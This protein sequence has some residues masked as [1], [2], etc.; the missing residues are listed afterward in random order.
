MVMALNLIPVKAQNK[1]VNAYVLEADLSIKEIPFIWRY[2]FYWVSTRTPLA[3]MMLRMATMWERPDA[4][5][6]QLETGGSR[7]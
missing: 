7:V 3:D 6:T 2:M 5:N 4:A 1:K